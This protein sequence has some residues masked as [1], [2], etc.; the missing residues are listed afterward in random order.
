M[1]LTPPPPAP[2]RGDR[3]TFSGRVDAF[4][5]WMVN[6]IGELN[7]F[8]AS[9]TTLSV[10][11]ANAFSYVFDANTADADPGPG[12]FRLSASPQDSS[13]VARLDILTADGVDISASLTALTNGTSSI[14]ASLR[15]QKL[16][17]PNAWMLFDV[18]SASGTGYRNFN[19]VLKAASSSNPFTGNDSIIVSIDRTG[20]AGTT[21]AYPYLKVIDRKTVSSNGG[22]S[23][24]NTTTV[25]VLNSV[26]VN[27]I[28]GSSLLT[29]TITLP[30][31][32]Y[33]A[34]ARA[35]AYNSGGNRLSL[36]N[37][38]DTVVLLQGAS[39]FNSTT[40]G[41]NVDAFLTGRFTLVSTKSVQLQH[42]FATGDGK[43]LGSAAGQAGVV[44]VF[45]ELELTK[46]N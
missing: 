22:A 16:N 40:G 30:A 35:P 6:L 23:A 31:G 4:L 17:N 10:G 24:S 3:A 29:N 41:N 45:S 44:E 21:G 7:T 42:W 18:T 20:D 19:V 14:K 5:L 33:E 34:R 2:Q 32:T 8:L 26:D 25:R 43:G 13:T 11:G 1:A 27:T 28:T 12:K 9:L 46:V 39:A 15:L 37:T 36:V 38:T